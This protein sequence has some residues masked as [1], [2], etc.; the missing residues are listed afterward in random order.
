MPG[1]VVNLSSLNF[2]LN[3]TDIAYTDIG[4]TIEINRSYNAYST[5]QGIFGRGWTFNYGVYLVADASGNITV[6]RGSGAEKLFTRNTDGTYTPP[7]GVYDK[8]TKNADGTFSLWVKN[9]KLT[10]NFYTFANNC[11]FVSYWEFNEGSGT[12]ATDSVGTNNGTIS[13]G[14]TWTSGVVGNALSFDGVNDYIQV[15]NAPALNSSH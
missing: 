6:M 4:R 7:K 1:L 5:Y 12:I 2:V 14:A 11:P 8:L 3:D 13:G 15:P 9:E 10:Y